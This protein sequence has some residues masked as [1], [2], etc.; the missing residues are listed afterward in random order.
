MTGSPKVVMPGDEIA[1]SEEYI[2]GEGTYERDG[3][4]LAA[5]PGHVELDEREKVARVVGFNPPPVLK[6]EAIV[7]GVV[8]EVRNNMVTVQQ[9]EIE[10]VGR[11]I[12]GD[13]M[14]TLHISKISENF[15]EDIREMFRLGDV[16]R[17]K[18]AQARPSIQLST[19]GA[20]LGVIK[21][22]CTKCREP[23]VP[24]K[25]GLWCDNCERTERRKTAK[26]YS[27]PTFGVPA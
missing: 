5:V 25:G 9:L 18:V 4:I 16:V 21:A 19:A 11:A 2:C 1:I 10:G 12:A 6:P 24:Q 14:G 23:L 3:K 20:E 13:D 22:F 26:G 17:A 7:L 8:S 27:T 15:T